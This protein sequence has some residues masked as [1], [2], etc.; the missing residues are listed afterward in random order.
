MLLNQ[1]E[2]GDAILDFVG[3]PGQAERSGR[4]EES[5]RDRRWCRLRDRV[6]DRQ[7]IA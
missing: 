6:S 5:M 1:L 3:P 4:P 2:E 7:G